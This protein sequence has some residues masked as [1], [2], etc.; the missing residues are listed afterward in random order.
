MEELVELKIL[1]LE[2]NENLSTLPD[3]ICSLE[4]LEELNLSSTG[5]FRLPENIN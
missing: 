2:G 4:K 3:T 1:S 5:V